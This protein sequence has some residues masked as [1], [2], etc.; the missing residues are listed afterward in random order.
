MARNRTLH[1][2]SKSVRK[3]YGGVTPERGTA[4]P[5]NQQQIDTYTSKP[6]CYQGNNHVM[7]ERDAIRMLEDFLDPRRPLTP[8]VRAALHRIADAMYIKDDWYPDIIL[9]AAHDIDTAFFMGRLE[10]NVRI[11][12]ISHIRMVQQL[13]VNG[14]HT[15]GSTRY[16]CCG[17][18][19]IW[20]SLRAIFEETPFPRRRMWQVLFHEMIVSPQSILR[21]DKKC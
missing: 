19:S 18:S 15:L 4:Y 10:G 3:E 20:L 6:Y 17:C 16:R 13:G 11:Q 14:A 12:W 9:K 8:K 21:T 5:C 2:L 7:S 1:E